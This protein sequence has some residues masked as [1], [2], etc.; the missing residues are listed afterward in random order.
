M[1]NPLDLNRVRNGES[2]YL[3]RELFSKCYPEIPV[4]EKTPMPRP[5]DEYFKN[6]KG[7]RR[8]EFRDDIDMSKLSGNQK[9]QLYC[10]EQFLNMIEE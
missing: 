9:W 10:L 2:K 6:W 3:I 4:P 7:P 5:V 1:G 8:V